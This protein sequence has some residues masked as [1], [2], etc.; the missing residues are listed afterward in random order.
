M[1][2]GMLLLA[3]CTWLYASAPSYWVLVLLLV[4]ARQ[5]SITSSITGQIAIAEIFG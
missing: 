3:T 1:V 5:G 2:G 4:V